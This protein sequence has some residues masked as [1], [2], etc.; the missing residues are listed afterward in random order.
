MSPDESTPLLEV[1]QL[2]VAAPSPNGELPLVREVSLRVGRGERLA[3]VGESG[4]GKSLVAR[5]IAGLNRKLTVSGSVRLGGR[6]LLDLSSRQMNLVR[7]DRISMVLQ[8]PMASLN[9]LM[10][11]G[12]QVAEPLIIAG[13]GRRE[14]RDAAIRMLDELGIPQA[15][16]AAS[17]YPHEL[18]GGMR[19]RVML[20]AALIAEPELLI[21]DEPTTAL[22]VRVQRQVL[23]LLHAVAAE[24]SLTVVMITHDLSVVAGFADRVA[25]MYA[26]RKVHE[27]RVDRLFAEPAH[28][29]TR[30]LLDAIPRLDDPGA[31]LLPIAGTPPR[32]G[33][34]PSGC[35][36]HPRCP[37]AVER[38][39][40][41]VP[42]TTFADDSLE[43]E[44]HRPLLP[45]EVVAR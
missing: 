25:T 4:S 40:V 37:R 10:T 19:Q 33:A 11:V 13:R 36:F 41:D 21:A 43:F 18:S 45:L 1:T 23:E 7:R 44:C 5:S 22:D 6:E 30:A 27:D 39:A 29:Y 12:A 8:D 24:R 31:E 34:L 3:I 17:G 2:S 38:C 20:A 32:P 14:S 28:P 9:P 26:G 15:R 42:A 35:S 16:S